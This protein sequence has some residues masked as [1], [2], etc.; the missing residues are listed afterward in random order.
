M[1]VLRCVLCARE[2]VCERESMVRHSYSRFIRS[3]SFVHLCCR[4]TS[5]SD[6]QLPS[7]SQC[8]T[9]KAT[10]RSVWCIHHIHIHNTNT[11]LCWF[12]K[13]IRTSLG[14]NDTSSCGIAENPIPKFQI[15]ARTNANESTHHAIRSLVFYLNHTQ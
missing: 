1:S 7:M 2:C 4:P 6:S 15:S 13:H 14:W 10:T 8:Y 12:V 11:H 3:L 5:Q 9:I